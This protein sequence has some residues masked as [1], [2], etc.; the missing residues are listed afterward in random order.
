MDDISDIENKLIHFSKKYS[1]QSTTKKI[2]KLLPQIEN[3]ISDGLTLDLITSF[4]NQQGIEVSKN[5]LKVIIYRLRKKK[6]NTHKKNTLPETTQTELTQ[7]KEN[8][9][10]RSPKEQAEFDELTKKISAFNA[11]SGWQ[12]R[13]LALGG[14]IDEIKGRSETEKR[15]LTMQLKSSISRR[16]Q[17]Y[18]Y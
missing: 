6:H 9:Q 2:S 8:S 5:T 13:Y 1:N 11:A 10:K 17:L 15:H 7:N 4:L 18:K 14:D 16:L 3:A 12:D